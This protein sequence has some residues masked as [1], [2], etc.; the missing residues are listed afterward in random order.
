MQ[1]TIQKYRNQF[2]DLPERKFLETIINHDIV[3]ETQF[4]FSFELTDFLLA[5]DIELT[6]QTEKDNY[7]IACSYGSLSFMYCPELFRELTPY[8]LDA[9]IYEVTLSNDEGT[10]MAG[11]LD[12]ESYGYDP[13]KME[14]T[15]QLMS[16]TKFWLNIWN[17]IML[18]PAL[19]RT[20]DANYIMATD[21]FKSI[22]STHKEK[23]SLVTPLDSHTG[24]TF[25]RLSLAPE[26]YTTL[27]N[28]KIKAEY[29]KKYCFTF[30]STYFFVFPSGTPHYADVLFYSE[31]ESPDFHS[32][33]EK[34]HYYDKFSQ[35]LDNG[36]MTRRQYKGI[37]N[38][39]YGDA[40]R[41]LF[42]LQ[43][44]EYK[45]SDNSYRPATEYHL[46]TKGKSVTDFLSDFCKLQGLHL[47]INEQYQL[48]LTPRDKA[49]KTWD[50]T[51]LIKTEPTFEF[52]PRDKASCVTTYD[53]MFEGTRGSGTGQIKFFL[54]DVEDNNGQM[55]LTRTL[56]P[57]DAPIPPKSRN[58]DGGRSTGYTFREYGSN[59]QTYFDDDGAISLA[60][61]QGLITEQFVP[62]LTPAQIYSRFMDMLRPGMM[63]KCRLM[64]TQVTPWDFLVWQGV[65]YKVTR[66]TINSTKEEAEIEAIERFRTEATLPFD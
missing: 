23:Y 18:D 35:L 27:G 57:E 14:H 40:V 54:V 10:V 53:I 3:V 39:S 43:G 44:V 61:D 11:L 2:Y 52:S 28:L 60:F 20:E 19:I 13:E 37:A 22:I 46:C 33:E 50:I 26:T 5:S 65:Q 66:V 55:Q 47:Y 31:H 42:E 49:V 6:K 4:P 51:D 38:M 12:A 62:V 7:E 15:F 63:L 16:Y 30:S 21:I 64:T 9:Y 32:D 8:T 56:V 41:K 29:L 48:V 59:W 25:G 1:V 58:S 36:L 45:R 34:K 24:P 17:S